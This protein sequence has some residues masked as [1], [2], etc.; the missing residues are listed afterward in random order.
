MEDAIGLL[1]E[2]Y[3]KTKNE[4]IKKLI[5]SLKVESPRASLESGTYNEVKVLS[6]P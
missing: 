6:F 1:E 3:E 2:G 5:D 4:E